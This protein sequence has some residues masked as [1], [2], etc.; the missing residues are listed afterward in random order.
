MLTAFIISYT[1]KIK[2]YLITLCNHNKAINNLVRLNM[3]QNGFKIKQGIKR[4][5][6]LLAFKVK[7]CCLS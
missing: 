2:P 1:N 3:N 6:C 5:F 7:T 4:T